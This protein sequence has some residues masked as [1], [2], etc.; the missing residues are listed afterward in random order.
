MN[1]TNTTARIAIQAND[2]VDRLGALRAQ[3]AELEAEAKP[4]VDELK[5]Q[6]EG[7]YEGSLFRAK[8]TEVAGRESFDSAAMEAKLRSLGVD[9][10]F[11]SKIT[12]TSAPSL[13]L[14]VT[15]R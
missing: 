1:M 2:P 4:I 3:I 13:R 5:A 9:N 11:F 12:K 10:R 14:T 6:G 15:D 8:I 7:V